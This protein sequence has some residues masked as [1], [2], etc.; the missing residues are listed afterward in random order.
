MQTKADKAIRFFANAGYIIGGVILFLLA[1]A[2][3]VSAVF[4]IVRDIYS[5]GF[6]VYSLLDEVALL[7]FAIAVIDVVKYL[8]TE[9][10]LHEGEKDPKAERRSLTKFFVIIVTALSLEGL[11]VTIETAKTDISKVMYPIAFFA[12]ATFLIIGVGIYQY[13]NSLS[14]RE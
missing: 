5:G 10:V 4:G 2:I 1:I 11:V 8:M 7:I 14:E 6:T 9:E 12:I 13:L 3:I